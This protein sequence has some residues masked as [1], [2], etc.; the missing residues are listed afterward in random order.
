[1][2]NPLIFIIAIV[3][4]SITACK[5]MQVAEVNT[6]ITNDDAAA[7]V[8]GA[9]ASSSNGLNSLSGDITLNSQYLYSNAGGCGAVRTD[10]VSRQNQSGSNITCSFK[11]KIVS[12]LN[13]NTNNVAENISST[14]TF[15]GNYS[16]PKL[17]AHGNGSLNVTVTGLAPTTPSYV[18]NGQFKNMSGFKLK[19]DTTRTGTIAIHIAIKNLTITKATTV[20]PAMITSGSATAT[21]TGNSPKGAFLF[22]G[23]LT[24][25][26][27]NEAV[28]AWG[29]KTYVVNLSTGAVAKK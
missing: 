4:T 11:Q 5:K 23:T 16:A 10:T 3:F 26:G 9:L 1:M 25:M 20:A 17:S 15:S 28:L 22:E 29:S 18:I 6:A 2:K 21:I 27:Y 14:L 19:S 13:C 8:A 7:M 12:K 24:F